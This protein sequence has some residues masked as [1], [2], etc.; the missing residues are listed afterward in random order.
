[1]LQVL[2][3]PPEKLEFSRSAV[4]CHPSPSAADSFLWVLVDGKMMED[5][6]SDLNGEEMQE[7][8]LWLLEPFLKGDW[9]GLSLIHI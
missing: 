2:P 5:G 7:A 3:I 6:L 1:M 8:C 9:G 4:A